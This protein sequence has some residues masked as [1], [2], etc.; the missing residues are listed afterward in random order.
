MKPRNFRR[1]STSSSAG[2]RDATALDEAVRVARTIHQRVRYE[3]SL[4]SSAARDAYL[5]SLMGLPAVRS[6]LFDDEGAD[7]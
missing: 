3:R 5:R 2:V 4:A 6:S 7:A 1:S